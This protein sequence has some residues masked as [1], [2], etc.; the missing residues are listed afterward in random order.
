AGMKN[1]RYA[2]SCCSGERVDFSEDFGQRGAR[3][4]AV[5]HDVVGGDAAHG[6]ESGFAT[7]PDESALSFSLREAD[8]GTAVR[9][10]D[11]VDV[12]HAGF[13]FGDGAVELDEEQ[14]AA[15]R[16]V[17]VDGGF[18]GLNGERV[19]HFDRSGENAGGDDAADG[20]AGLIA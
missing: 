14:A 17:G 18:G 8:F 12:L 3:D 20:S 10:P 11:F 6:G 7:L 4:N 13:D 19:H 1:V 16:V 5:L 2:K 15:H 9:E